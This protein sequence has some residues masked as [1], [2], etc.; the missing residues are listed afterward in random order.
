VAVFGTTAKRPLAL[1]LVAALI[2]TSTPSGGN[3]FPSS[4]P[5]TGSSSPRVKVPSG[6][7]AEKDAVLRN[8]K[9]NPSKVPIQKKIPIQVNPEKGPRA[10]SV[11][12]PGSGP[13][14]G[15]GTYDG[16]PAGQPGGQPGT[17]GGTGGGPPPQGGPSSEGQ[18]PRPG[19]GRDNLVPGVLIGAA[20]VIAIGALLARERAAA[21]QPSQTPPQDQIVDQLLN[22]GPILATA[23]NMSAF[24]V[25][26]FV[27]GN[28]PL[29]IDFQQ[30]S[31]G[32]ALL[33]I[34][35]RD[36]P[37]VFSYDLSAACPP[38]RRCLIQMR[39]PP[40]IFGD[41]L[42]PAVI[43]ATATGK[44]G[45]ET[46]AEFDVFALGAGPRAV[47]SVAIDGVSFG[48]S[49][50]R[51]TEQQRALY[52]FY[53]HSDFGNTSVEFWKVEN[54][55]DGV[56]HYLV[57]DRLIEGGVRRNQWIGVNERREWDGTEKGRKVSSGRHK[58]QVR[59]WDRVG[60][61]V[62]AWSNDVVLVE[63]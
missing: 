57:D 59:A 58:V 3:E 29:L 40:E 55:G 56:R 9:T 27:R 49:T 19:G 33:Q 38:P 5:S 11:V 52:R 30:R 31:P 62:T 13:K 16:P 17:P 51:V 50:I 43:A 44:Q 39:L 60:D 7:R 1:V 35:A 42:R 8:P 46:Q 14:G 12:V 15:G 41:G 24:A 54:G 20:A 26:G 37:E 28:W 53:S 61:W 25:R 21:S 4:T 32:T 18:P 47:G 2:S 23:F 22:D 48:P 6:V 36:L 34:S 10:D 63:Q 45:N